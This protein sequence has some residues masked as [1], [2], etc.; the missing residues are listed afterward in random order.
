MCIIPKAK[1]ATQGQ[2]SQPEQTATPQDVGQAR[3]Q[4]NQSL[5]GGVPDLRIDPSA[6]SGGAVA[7]GSGLKME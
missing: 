1:V 3:Q 7:G 4:E 5:F 6:S 2:A